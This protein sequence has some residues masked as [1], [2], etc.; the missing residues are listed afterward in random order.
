MQNIINFVVPSPR[1]KIEPPPDWLSEKC[2]TGV[3]W[4]GE[5]AESER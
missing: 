2:P 5:L 3:N 1:D 4:N